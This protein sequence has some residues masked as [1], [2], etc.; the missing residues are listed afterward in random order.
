MHGEYNSRGENT[1]LM[2]KLLTQEDSS[3][4]DSD[5]KHPPTNNNRVLIADASHPSSEMPPWEKGETQP[6][7]FRDWPFAILFLA[8]LLLV[9]FLGSWYFPK[10]QTESLTTFLSSQLLNPVTLS[11]FG[12]SLI[13]A[14]FYTTVALNSLQ[15][16]GKQI[17]SI[18]IWFSVLSS[19]VL[20]ILLTLTGQ[21]YMVL[22]FAFAAF[23][24]AWYALSITHRIPFAAANLHA[25]IQVVNTN[26]GLW[27]V[28]FWMIVFGIIYTILWT[29]AL[30]GALDFHMECSDDSTNACDWDWNHERTWMYLPFVLFLLFTQQ[31]I[32]NFGHTVCSGIAASWYFDPPSTG[33]WCSNA[34]LD[35]VKRSITTTFGSICYGSLL[36]AAVQF[37]RFVVHVLRQNR[38]EEHRRGRSRNMDG[39]ESLLLCCLDCIIGIVED[40]VQY[41]NKWAFIYV[42]V[43]GY[44]YT[45]AGKKVMTLFQA[46]GWTIIINDN[47][48]LSVLNFI[49][50]LIIGLVALTSFV[51]GIDLI[52]LVPAFIFPITMATLLDSIVSTILVCFAEAPFDLEENHPLHS[53]EIREGC[54]Q[55]Y[56]QLRF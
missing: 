31:V 10:E 5:V 18:S 22:P 36:V 49:V 16:W 25:A 27:F 24:G 33:G 19:T 15:K 38:E 37:L 32:S 26:K 56:P 52:L 28:N 20:S 50:G 9:F 45:K 40:L 46:R 17:I 34:I 42:G 23:F 41:F 1:H 51:F 47:I 21:W 53:A 39:V 55:A 8:Q 35:S 30:Y 11:Q 2:E 54:E 43:Y 4:Q 7:A 44:N 29:M 14:V 6:K 12:F 3:K 13:V 48:V